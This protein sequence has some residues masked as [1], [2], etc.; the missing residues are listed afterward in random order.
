MIFAY[1]I[2]LASID[3]NFLLLISWLF[4]VNISHDSSYFL[5]DIEDGNYWNFAQGVQ[6]FI[7]LYYS[8][9]DTG[10]PV[11]GSPSI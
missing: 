5:H 8:P 6:E 2:L 3:R 7:S 4:A 10:I 9:G 1:R 11:T